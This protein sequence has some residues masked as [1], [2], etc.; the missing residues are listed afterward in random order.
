MSP[1]SPEYRALIF[2]SIFYVVLG[3]FFFSC[4]D[5]VAK[6]LRD[7]FSTFQLLTISGLFGMVISGGIIWFKKGKAGFKSAKWKAHIFR[8][9]VIACSS[10]FAVTAFKLLPLTDFYAIVFISPFLSKIF[11]VFFLKEHVGWRRWMATGVAF[12]GVLVVAGPQFNDM[13]V[14][15]LYAFMGAFWSSLSVIQARR[16]GT[17]DYTPL[18]A[19][20]PTLF[21][22][23]INGLCLWV[24]G[25]VNPLSLVA[26]EHIPFLLIHAP[27]VVCGIMACSKG[28]AMAPLTA[29]VTPFHYTQIIW[30]TIFGFWVFH[31]LPSTTTMIGLSLIISAGLYSIYREYSLTRAHKT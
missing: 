10:Y 31:Q 2:R 16:I 18:Y 1:T 22:F 13:G 11:A 14:G 4:A 19:F 23:L 17:D 26:R 24:F 3:Y 20:Y 30:G 28:F 21:V 9:L 15:Y 29:M 6:I 5:V 7:T 12:S 25:E 27:F 8:G